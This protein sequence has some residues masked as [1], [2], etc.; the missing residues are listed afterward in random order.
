MA[1]AR[2]EAIIDHAIQEDR[3]IVTL[4]ADFHALIATKGGAGLGYLLRRKSAPPRIAAWLKQPACHPTPR[5]QRPELPARSSATVHVARVCRSASMKQANPAWPLRIR[6]I[7]R[8]C[9]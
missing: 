4:D 3:V 8:H 9:L 2:D 7:I 1:A 5:R 6:P